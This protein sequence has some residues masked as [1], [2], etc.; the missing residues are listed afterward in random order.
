[1]TKK[2]FPQFFSSAATSRKARLVGLLLLIL[3][4]LAYLTSVALL[5]RTDPNM[6]VGLQIG[7]EEALRLATDYAAK[8]LGLNVERWSAGCRVDPD[9]DVHLY[10]RLHSHVPDAERIRRLAPDAF[11]HTIFLAPHDGEKLEVLL[12]TD[13]QPF[14]FVHTLPPKQAIDD[15]GDAASRALAENA[16]R[17]LAAKDNLSLAGEPELSEQRN[18]NYVARRYTWTHPLPT[19]PELKLRTAITVAGDAVVAEERTGKVEAEYASKNLI[20]HRPAPTLAV[21]GSYLLIGV[22][23]LYGLYRYIQRARQKEVAHARSLL[24]C[25]AIAVIYMFIALQTDFDKFSLPPNAPNQTAIYWFIMF[26]TAVAFLL[27]GLVIGLA[28]GSSEGDTR[29]AYPGKLTS[30]DALI[31]GKIFSKNVARAVCVGCAIG[32]WML[33]ARTLVMLPWAA[34]AGA[35]SGLMEKTYGIILGHH[36]SLLP[37]MIAPLTAIVMAVPGLLLPLSFLHGRIK[38]K[39][40]LLGIL[41]L[42][43][44]ITGANIFQDRPLTFTAGMLLALVS[45]GALL[46]P[47]FAFDLLTAIVGL[48]A[49][50]LVSFSFYL[51]S[52]PVA[53]LS[54]AGYLS[55]AIAAAFFLVELLF[56]YRGREYTEAQVRPLYARHLAERLT[57]Q[58][59]VSA[60]REAQIRL[61]P[62]KLPEVAG[63]TLAAACRPAHGVGGDFYDLFPLAGERLGV[64]VAEGGSHGLE[65]AMIIAYAKGFLMPRLHDEHKPSEIICDLQTRLTPMLETGQAL[66]LVYAVVDRQQR[67]LSYACTGSYPEVVVRRNQDGAQKRG[68]LIY[69]REQEVL[70]VSDASPDFNC[71]VRE[72]SVEMSAGDAVLFYTDGVAHSFGDDAEAS[73]EKWV[74]SLLDGRARKDNSL[75]TLLGKSLEKQA[76]RVR[77]ASVE[78]DLTAVVVRLEANDKA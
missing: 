28:Y 47:F 22:F 42:L 67:T 59:E 29:E 37:L 68:G 10:Y 62:Q 30:L 7:R 72:A 12:T 31:T 43:S 18:F 24:L 50:S 61:L 48:A 3:S 21:A 40:L 66:A 20:N 23:V 74:A 34:H 71:T 36:P 69:T 9:N 65:A 52:Q 53:S 76:R 32:G 16:M 14:G 17:A 64:F 35:G 26:S 6:R 5:R 1:M 63:L 41:I 54:R 51:A 4:P 44:I 45:A 57:L 77:R 19:L 46:I 11:V 25:V 2:L 56:V 38:S 33:L 39:S 58:A 8:E 75:Q 70:V 27:F 13:G 49:S 15:R 73:A 60:A 78:D 55:L